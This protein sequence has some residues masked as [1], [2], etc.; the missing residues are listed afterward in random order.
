MDTHSTIATEDLVERLAAKGVTFP[1]PASVDIAPE[2][3]P[4]RI[5]GDGVVIHAGSRIRGAHTVISA[6]CEIGREGPAT[7][8]DCWL[9]PEVSLKGGYFAK[10]VYLRGANMGLGA[11]VREGT[12][13]EEEAGGAH[14]VGLKQTIL[15]PFVTLG[16]LINFCDCLMAGGTSRKDH[17]EVGSSYIHFNFTPDGNKSTASLFGDVARG[18]MLDQP[19]IFLGGQGGAVGPVVTGF[20]TVVGAGSVLRSDVEDDGQLVL[21]APVAGLQRP[22]TPRRYK[23]LAPLVEKNIT[24]IAN[25]VA[26]RA[27]YQQVRSWFFAEQE[28][29]PLILEGALTQLDSAHAERTKRLKALIVSVAPDTPERA[30]LVERVDQVLG[31]CSPDTADQAAAPDELVAQL[32][33]AATAGTQYTDAVQGLNEAERVAGT[34][35][36]GGIVER[37]CAEAGACVPAMGLFGS[38]Q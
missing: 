4:D 30:E 31:A 7:L 38:T 34:Q 26:L 5:S 6:G 14:T 36:L 12:I 22:N 21:P 2:V 8:E 37:I 27:W 32:R 9:G 23:K 19:P 10:S 28:F 13:L 3:D 11:H 17:S 33:T 1:H 18:V 15:F 24:Y 20:G 25:L 16:S 29:G 35:W